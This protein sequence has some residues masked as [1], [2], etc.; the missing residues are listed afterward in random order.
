MKCGSKCSVILVMSFY[1]LTSS[2]LLA[3]ALILSYCIPEA[4]TPS[5]LLKVFVFPNNLHSVALNEWILD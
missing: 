5:E 2:Q 4:K 1:I 3:A